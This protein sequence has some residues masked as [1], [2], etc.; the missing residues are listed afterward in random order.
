MLN[1]KEGVTNNYNDLIK[2]TGNNELG[3]INILNKLF[4]EN[5]IGSIWLSTKEAAHILSLSENALR[6][7]VYRGQIKV[8]RLGR[9]LRFS[10]NDCLNLFKEKGINYGN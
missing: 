10:L 6:I 9:R 8:H 5:R 4:F 3:G 7:M 2:S 1:N